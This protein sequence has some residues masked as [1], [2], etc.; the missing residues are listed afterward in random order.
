MGPGYNLATGLELVPI[1]SNNTLAL[2]QYIYSCSASVWI[3][4]ERHFQP[5]FVPEAYVIGET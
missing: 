1:E 4:P 2:F 3:F 5:I